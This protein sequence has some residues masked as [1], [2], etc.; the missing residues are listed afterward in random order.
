MNLL[1]LPNDTPNVCWAQRAF[2]DLRQPF[3]T[4][5]EVLLDYH[6]QSRSDL[7]ASS[8]PIASP[9]S[10]HNIL[11]TLVVHELRRKLMG[12][13]PHGTGEHAPRLSLLASLLCASVVSVGIAPGPTAFATEL[14]EAAGGGRLVTAL[15]LL[16]AFGH[17]DLAEDTA[18]GKVGLSQKQLRRGSNK[19]L[20]P[21]KRGQQV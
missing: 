11:K 4:R 17:K 6:H 9:L 7:L 21:N 15:A 3:I 18:S 5:V 16:L 10:P 12:A 20:K 19:S 14:V 13:V 2:E 8:L 1:Q